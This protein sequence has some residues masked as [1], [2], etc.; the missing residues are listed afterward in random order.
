V[1]NS[2]SKDCLQVST[3]ARHHI[4]KAQTCGLQVDRRVGMLGSVKSREVWTSWVKGPD[5]ERWRQV[6]LW[7]G[8]REGKAADR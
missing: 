2:D 5:R 8:G 6:I 4:G 3:N 1:R 7:G